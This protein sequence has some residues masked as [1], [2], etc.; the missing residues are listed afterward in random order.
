MLTFEVMASNGAKNDGK[1][2]S[3]KEP[4]DTDTAPSILGKRPNPD[5]DFEWFIKPNS[6]GNRVRGERTR[7]GI[8]L[9]TELNGSV[10]GGKIID[11]DKIT[12]LGFIRLLQEK[13]DKLRTRFRSADGLSASIASMQVHE[14]SL[15]FA[16]EFEK[17]NKKII[18]STWWKLCGL[19]FVAAGAGWTYKVLQWYRQ[20]QAQVG[21]D[22]TVDFYGTARELFNGFHGEEKKEGSGHRQC[23]AAFWNEL[24]QYNLQWLMKQDSDGWDEAAMAFITNVIDGSVSGKDLRSAYDACYDWSS[25]DGDEVDANDRDGDEIEVSPGHHISTDMSADEF[26]DELLGKLGDKA[27]ALRDAMENTAGVESTAG[28]ARGLAEVVR[29]TEMSEEMKGLVMDVIET[30]QFIDD[31]MG[32]LS[33]GQVVSNVI[34]WADFHGVDPRQ[35][36]Q[37]IEFDPAEGQFSVTMNPEAQAL[38]TANGAT[39]LDTARGTQ[40]DQWTGNR[41]QWQTFALD[42]IKV[43]IV[44]SEASEIV[45]KICFTWKTFHLEDDDD[46]TTPLHAP[47]KVNG[48][49]EVVL[50]DGIEAACFGGFLDEEEEQEELSIDDENIRIFNTAFAGQLGFAE[51]YLPSIGSGSVLCFEIK[52]VE[53]MTSTMDGR[54]MSPPTI[55]QTRECTMTETQKNYS[56]RIDA[57]LVSTGVEDPGEDTSPSFTGG[58]NHDWTNLPTTLDGASEEQIRLAAAA[59]AMRAGGGAGGGTDGEA[60]AGGDEMQEVGDEE[61]EPITIIPGNVQMASIEQLRVWENSVKKHV[62]RCCVTNCDSCDWEGMMYPVSFKVTEMGREETWK[63]CRCAD[64]SLTLRNMC[65][66][67]FVGNLTNENVQTQV[68]AFKAKLGAN[69]AGFEYFMMCPHCRGVGPWKQ[70]ELTAADVAHY[71]AI[72]A[73]EASVSE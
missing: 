21:K 58:D 39:A 19:A 37:Q 10:G 50:R 11:T 34:N 3:D 18:K 72:A 27:A 67:C 64:R 53:T 16:K 49:G 46:V 73:A 5:P 25:K 4:M 61:E 15:V 17:E 69:V 68:A 7:V 65:Q 2:G 12:L 40:R 42:A 8:W 51:K 13:V 48:Q 41:S 35:P 38:A 32:E 71:N 70:L 55:H 23:F 56:V 20:K 45:Q 36:A 22:D 29:A 9:L 63:S 62:P 54:R 60:A 59:L 33:D 52:K 31:G 1:N 28:G 14:A 26:L 6:L 66:V 44:I 43:E 24:I 30:K 57:T 47:V